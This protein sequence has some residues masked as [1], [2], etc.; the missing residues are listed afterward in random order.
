MLIEPGIKMKTIALVLLFC[1][2]DAAAAG[3]KEAEA[4]LKDMEPPRLAEVSKELDGLLAKPGAA[5]AGDARAAALLGENQGAMELFRQAAEEPNDGYLFAPKPE[6]A[7]ANT[8]APKFA[9]Q[10]KLLK[11]L[12]IEA[13]IKAAGKRAGPAEKNLLA[14]AGLMSQLSAQRSAPVLSSLVLQL[15]LLKTYP[16]LSDSL[17]NPSASQAYL[18]ELAARLDKVLKNQDFM[19]SAML[20]EAEIAKAAMLA[21]VNPETMAAERAKLGFLQRLGA[22]K[23]QDQEFFDGIYRDYN[24]AVDA[25]AR[26]LIG[27][28]RANDPA[29]AAAFME[30]RQQELLAR[31]QARDQLS[32]AW[33]IIDGLKG[34][35]GAK[36]GMAEVLVDSW[37]NFATPAYEKLIPRYHLFLCKL[38]V[39]RSALAVTVYRR[40]Y[41]RLPDRLEQVVPTYLEAVPQDSFNKFGP[42]SYLRKGKNFSIYSFGPDG[43]DGGGAAAMDYDAYS[44]NPARDAGDIVFAD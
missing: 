23:L 39:L 9:A 33:G 37:L 2:A 42:L 43:K 10:L 4:L 19:R 12:L 27:T 25:H 31:K 5:L 29:P 21:G 41:K 6:K 8:P 34:G 16:V 24:A 20:A 18:G 14:A 1:F 32:T 36:K 13:K 40:A 35:P 7:G 26:V 11:L 38:N 28:F 3:Y 17:R 22:K 30:K 15:C 44:D